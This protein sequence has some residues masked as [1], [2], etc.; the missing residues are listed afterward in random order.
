M[1]DNP[2]R[3]NDAEMVEVEQPKAPPCE[4]HVLVIWNGKCW[5]L[6]NQ[7]F[8]GLDEQVHRRRAFHAGSPARIFRLSD[9]PSPSEADRSA[10]IEATPPE[11]AEAYALA[12]CIFLQGALYISG[13]K[14]DAVCNAWRLAWNRQ[15][16]IVRS[17]QSP[18]SGGEK[19]EDR[20]R[21]QYSSQGVP[22]CVNCGEVGDDCR[23][24]DY[25]SVK[26]AWLHERKKHIDA[27]KEIARLKSS[28][29]P[30]PCSTGKETVTTSPEATGTT[31]A[32]PSRDYLKCRLC[33][34]TSADIDP[35]TGGVLRLLEQ[36]WRA[37]N[38]RVDY[39]CPECAKEGDEKPIQSFAETGVKAAI[40]P[41][42]P[43]TPEQERAYWEGCVRRDLKLANVTEWNL[44]RLLDLHEVETAFLR[45]Q[46]REL[47]KGTEALMADASNWKNRYD[48]ACIE[49]ERLKSG[50]RK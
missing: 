3:V 12:G 26:A 36:G 22:R 35:A 28:L 45:A 33:G 43:E 10:V 11:V 17:L 9:S 19:R 13:T 24:N 23:C 50:G 21:E 4:G 47:S 1:P 40:H 2:P 6:E 41:V 5:S 27:L 30:A 39:E 42:F 25:Q 7:C 8:T 37:V 31:P 49:I 38:Q 34:S 20:L 14:F 16:A 46:N 18:P 44:T 29:P 15:A 48:Q 32:A